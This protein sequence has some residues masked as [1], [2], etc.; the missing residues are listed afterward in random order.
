MMPLNKTKVAVNISYMPA[1]IPLAVKQALALRGK[2][3]ML[4]ERKVDA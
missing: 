3:E 1:K 2:P 4:F